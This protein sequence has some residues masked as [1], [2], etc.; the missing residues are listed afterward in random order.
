MINDFKTTNK[1]NIFN[2]ISEF[3][4]LCLK[5]KESFRTSNIF[6]TSS[7]REDSFSR[8]PSCDYFRGSSLG[9]SNILSENFEILTT[10]K[11][12]LI[13]K[14]NFEG[15]HFKTLSTIG[16]GAYSKVVKAKNIKNHNIYAIKIIDKHFMD[17]E[18]KYYQIH[19]ENELLNMCDSPNIIQIYGAYEDDFYIYLVL[20]FCDE[21][22]L[23]NFIK[24]HGRCSIN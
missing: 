22:D 20:E 5:E 1:D 23:E 9:N 2:L 16:S 7:S 8:S 10:Q 6:N 21:G 15:S 13:S 4:G 3:E 19:L 14:S 12:K 24:K 18:K 11:K 17:K